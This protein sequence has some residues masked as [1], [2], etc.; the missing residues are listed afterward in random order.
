MTVYSL[1]NG[2]MRACSNYVCKI[3]EAVGENDKC[4]CYALACIAQYVET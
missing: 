2:G 1:I 3:V 4:T